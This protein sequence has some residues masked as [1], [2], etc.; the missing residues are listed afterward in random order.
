MSCSSQGSRGK[1]TNDCIHGNQQ[2]PSKI[3]KYIYSVLCLIQLCSTLYFTWIFLSQ[4]PPLCPSL[5]PHISTFP[6][7]FSTI[8]YLS[9]RCRQTCPLSIQIL[10]LPSALQSAHSLINHSLLA[11]LTNWSSDVSPHVPMGSTIFFERSRRT[12]FSSW[13]VT[14]IAWCMMAPTAAIYA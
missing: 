5:Q 13:S 6:G 1:P 12:H 2:P 9:A 11:Q 7:P 3:T 8:L 14:A 4:Y 10:P